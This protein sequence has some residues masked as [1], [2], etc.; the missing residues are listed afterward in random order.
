MIA[1]LSNEVAQESSANAL[2]SGHWKA[3]W[4]N[5][6]TELNSLLAFLGLSTND[7]DGD[8]ALD[9]KPTFPLRIPHSFA[10][11]MRKA[12]PRDPLLRQVLPLQAELSSPANF[13]A[14]PVADLAH[15]PSQGLIHKYRSR[16][17]LIATGTCAINCRYCFRREYPYAQASFSPR[18]WASAMQYLR[19][20][21]EVNEVILSGGDPLALDDTRL[22]QL[23]DALQTLPQLKRIRLHTRTPIVLPARVDN[24]F[25]AWISALKLPCVMVLHSNHAQEWQDA[26]LIAAMQS[27]KQAGVTLLNQAVLLRDINDSAAAQIALS[28]ALFDA[29]VLPYYLNL[30]D[31]VTG[32]AHFFVSDARAQAL[33][34]AM[35]AQ[36]PGYLLPKL[37]RD[38]PGTAAKQIQSS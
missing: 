14:D 12:D 27:L 7:F 15:S 22:A 20:H 19:A 33:Y 9:L 36:L 24:G 3:Q 29:G 37:V 17:L 28:E 21:P 30:L 13:I 2:H 31:P 23:S 16:V 26:T 5:S 6:F 1:A 38:A 10:A 25:L 4:R 34:T 11:R 18:A 8:L 35:A 32:S